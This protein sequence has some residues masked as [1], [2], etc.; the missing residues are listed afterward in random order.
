MGAKEVSFSIPAP[1][2]KLMKVV[3][4][5]TSPLI[6]HRWSEKAINMI[7]DKQLKKPKQGRDARNPEEEYSNSF[8]KS[9]DGY[10]SFPALSIKQAMV[11]A[12]RNIEGITMT[13]LRGAIFVEG[14]KDGMIKV[15]VDKKAAKLN[16]K[17]TRYAEGEGA[18]NTVGFAPGYKGKI[19]MRQDMVRVGMGS[20]DIRFRG[21]LKDWSMNFIVKFNES[22]FSAEQVLNLLQTAGFACGLGEWRPEKNGSYGTFEIK[23]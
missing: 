11:N 2:I 14:D 22:L 16:G 18:E 15:L 8:Y 17:V 19:E 20:A 1:K 10:I 7:L 21:Q 3:I 12:A 6:F 4:M 5:G 23:N 13:L 9:V